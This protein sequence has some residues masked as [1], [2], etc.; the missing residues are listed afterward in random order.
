MRKE[1]IVTEFKV[2]SQHSPGQ[3]VENYKNPLKLNGKAIL[4][5]GREGP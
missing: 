5:T 2:L 4:V 3:T 1:R